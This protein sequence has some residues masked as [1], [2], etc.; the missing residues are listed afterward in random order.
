MTDP[1]A[2]RSAGLS[3]LILRVIS[4][5]VLAPIA[6][7]VAWIG[8]VP[9]VVFWTVAA[10]IVLWEWSALMKNATEV[11][12]SLGWFAGWMVAATSRA[13]FSSRA[14]DS[15]RWGAALSSAHAISAS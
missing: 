10:S 3:N 13:S 1:A 4:S 7:L 15:R 8:G 11:D 6:I 9:F 12:K 2:P 5:A 14:F